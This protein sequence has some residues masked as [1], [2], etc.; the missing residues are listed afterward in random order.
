MKFVSARRFIVY[1]LI[2]TI[3]LCFGVG[4]SEPEKGF[5]SACDLISKEKVGEI[6]GVKIDKVKETQRNEKG[7]IKLSICMFFASDD[8]SPAGVTVMIVYD[9]SIIDPK[10]A[11][12][13]HIKSFRESIGEPDYTFEPV[14]DVGGAAIYDP[15]V[16]QLAVFEKGNKTFYQA[17]GKAPKTKLIEVARAVLAK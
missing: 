12:E 14:Q 16:K 9:P 6:F 7:D 5:P 4:C 15:A 17:D 1:V 2:M 10:K 11:V 8:S 13:N 3:P